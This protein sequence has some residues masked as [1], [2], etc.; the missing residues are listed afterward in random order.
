MS[1]CRGPE[2]DWAGRA[3]HGHK[4]SASF[5]DISNTIVSLKGKKKREKKIK[6]EKNKKRYGK[7]LLKYCRMIKIF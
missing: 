5:P 7:L 3:R 6:I 4:S 2:P 1:P